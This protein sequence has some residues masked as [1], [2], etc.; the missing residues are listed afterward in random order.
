MAFLSLKKIKNNLSVQ[1]KIHIHYI[2]YVLVIVIA[3][4][5]NTINNILRFFLRKK[6]KTTFIS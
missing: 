4:I 6:S 1:I 2:Y 5:L 3:I